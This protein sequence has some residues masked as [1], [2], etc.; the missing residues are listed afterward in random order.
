MLK[1]EISDLLLSQCGKRFTLSL[2]V[3]TEGK[4]LYRM[5]ENATVWERV[6]CHS[7]M[8]KAAAFLY[9]KHHV[10]KKEKKYMALK[11][12]VINGKKGE[13]ESCILLEEILLANWDIYLNIK[14]YEK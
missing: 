9:C 5:Y 3:T 13:R 6:D 4:V 8:G 7:S 12:R 14:T 2:S 1:N 10:L 11:S